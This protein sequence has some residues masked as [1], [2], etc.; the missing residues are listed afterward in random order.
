VKSHAAGRPA[1]MSCATTPMETRVLRF[2]TSSAQ[3]LSDA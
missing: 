3:I 1:A 2:M